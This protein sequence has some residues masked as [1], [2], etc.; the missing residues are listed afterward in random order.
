MVRLQFLTSAITNLITNMRKIILIVSAVLVSLV[1]KAQNVQFQSYEDTANY[2]TGLEKNK[3]VYIDKPFSFFYNDLRIKPVRIIFN[4]GGTNLK[5]KTDYG[6]SLRFYFNG[7]ED[8]SKKHF[9]IL[10]W[11]THPSSEQLYPLL[12]PG[13]GKP[14]DLNAIINL[15]MGHV[16]RD[17]IV[18][19]YGQDDMKLAPVPIE[20]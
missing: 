8:F 17:I 20:H 11:Y 6:R 4:Y 14:Q 2:L 7:E 13:N 5:D 12:F 9:I 18:K 16:L 1:V 3:S 15:Y 19:D 10:N